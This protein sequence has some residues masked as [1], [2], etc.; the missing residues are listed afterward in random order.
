MVEPGGRTAAE[1]SVREEKLWRIIRSLREELRLARKTNDSLRNQ[2][3]EPAVCDW[4]VRSIHAGPD[5]PPRAMSKLDAAGSLCLVEQLM[6]WRLRTKIRAL[7]VQVFCQWQSLARLRLQRSLE[8]SRGQQP[9]HHGTGQTRQWGQSELMQA[10]QA[11]CLLVR[12][13]KKVDQRRDLSRLSCDFSSN[14]TCVMDSERIAPFLPG[15]PGSSDLVSELIE[16][17]TQLEQA[18]GQICSSDHQILTSS[19]PKSP[20]HSALS[21]GQR[22][23]ARDSSSAT[24]RG[25]S[26]LAEM[27]RLEKDGEEASARAALAMQGCDLEARIAA[28]SWPKLPPELL[29]ER[30]YSC[31]RILTETTSNQEQFAGDGQ[32]AIRTDVPPLQ[33]ISQDRHQTNLAM[34]AFERGFGPGQ[35]AWRGRRPDGYLQRHQPCLCALLLHPRTTRWTRL[36]PPLPHPY[37]RRADTRL[38]LPATASKTTRGKIQSLDLTTAAVRAEGTHDGSLW[39]LQWCNGLK[40]L[41]LP[42]RPHVSCKCKRREDAVASCVG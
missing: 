12:A 3:L 11:W 32:G 24:I 39:R 17:V 5:S 37:P 7:V 9:R 35:Q 33:P 38:C 8:C 26:A 41:S 34:A 10:F 21:Q 1:Q 28:L 16:V 14:H 18:H 15:Q 4:S 6:A 27:M 42:Q 40:I 20:P 22:Q 29:S 13:A 2:P 30:D 36:A 25:A 19:R 23:A 31:R